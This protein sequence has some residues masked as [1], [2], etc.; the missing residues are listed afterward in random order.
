M[1]FS[2]Q[3]AGQSQRKKNVLFPFEEGPGLSIPEVPVVLLVLP[4]QVKGFTFT[5][6]LKGRCGLN[7]N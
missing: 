5:A 1:R 3:L 7:T 4:P 6:R 2:L